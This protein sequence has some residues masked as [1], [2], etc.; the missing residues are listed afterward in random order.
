VLSGLFF[1]RK[2]GIPKSIKSAIDAVDHFS[3]S[4]DAFHER[5]VPRSNVFTV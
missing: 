3:V 1:A 4:M 2:P 5:E